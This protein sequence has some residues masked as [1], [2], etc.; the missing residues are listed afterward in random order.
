MSP[1]RVVSTRFDRLGRNRAFPFEGTDSTHDGTFSGA[2]RPRS[3]HCRGSSRRSRVLEAI[4]RYTV[5]R[6][7]GSSVGVSRPGESS[8][9]FG[10]PIE[11]SIRSFSP[12]RPA[13]DRGIRHRVRRR[14][15]YDWLT[16]SRDESFR[17]RHHP[18][19]EGRGTGRRSE[20][21]SRTFGDAASPRKPAVS[22]SF[23][24]TR[25]AHVCFSLRSP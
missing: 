18:G 12:Q 15:C 8:V 6:T 16:R 17:F 4:T 7:T 9:I 14:T 19:N 20:R 3:P 10:G 22:R 1:H 21:L 5:V 24:P 13:I 25:S 11:G 23:R 2:L